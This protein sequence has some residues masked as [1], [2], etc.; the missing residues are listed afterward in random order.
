MTG[1]ERSER[2]QLSHKRKIIGQ[3]ERPKFEEVSFGDFRHGQV[4]AVAW[5][6]R[7]AQKDS[8]TN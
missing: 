4:D 1:G 3:S 6:A 8:R 2:Y 7:N 5:G